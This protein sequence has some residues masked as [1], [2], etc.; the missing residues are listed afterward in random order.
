VNCISV[1]DEIVHGIPSGRV[2]A[3]G[4]LVKLDV[5]AEK[6]GFMADAAVTVPVGRASGRSRTLVRCAERALRRALSVARAGR[7]TCDVGLAV[8]EVV[9]RAGFSVV[10]ALHGHGIGRTIHEDPRVP[11]WNDPT[12]RDWLTRG[13]VITIEPLVAMGSGDAVGDP[14]GWT[15]RTRDGS[16]AAHVEHTIVVTGGAPIVLTAA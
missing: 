11:N 1:N 16:L 5:T 10:R 15:V 14:D 13:L 7:R 12:A 9:E 2:L 8:Q 3:E 4:D 6:D